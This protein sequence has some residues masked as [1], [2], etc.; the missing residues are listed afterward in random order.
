MVQYFG[1]S[2]ESNLGQEPP[3]RCD[4]M[5]HFRNFFKTGMTGRSLPGDVM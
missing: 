5:V 3:R 1:G 2:L 4:V